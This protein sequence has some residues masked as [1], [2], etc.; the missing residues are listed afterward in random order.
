MTMTRDR[1]IACGMYAFTDA[2]RSAWR[3]LFERFFEIAG[4]AP[5]QVALSFEHDPGL[6]RQ[7]GL[8]FGHTCGYPLMTRLRDHVAPFC[9][10]LFDVPGTDGKLYSSR[11]IT[12]LD[13]GIE[14][15]ADCRDRVCAINNPD[16]N[17]GMNV[18]RHALADLANGEPFFERVL[19][20]G[21][22][23]HSF[24]AVASGD[25]ALAAIDCVS[26]QLIVDARPE[27]AARVRVIGD[28]VKSCGL[29]LVM[30]HARV[31]ASD[32]RILI[33][34][35]QQALASCPTETSATLH[36][37]GFAEVRLDDYQAILDIEGYA[38]ERGYAELL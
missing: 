35:L 36:L 31:A 29:P 27:L 32:T 10:P 5:G 15:L 1:F 7:P 8:W 28:S 13:S 19:T 26:Y 34:Q 38:V 30:A 23:L 4:V 20:T 2:Q 17:S 12:A 9:V 22:H 24:A 11:F 16:S 25:A 21:G 6:L 37:A 3:S 18:L 14:S 33:A